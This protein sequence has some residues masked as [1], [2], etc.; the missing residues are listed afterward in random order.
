LIKKGVNIFN[1]MLTKI[2]KNDRLIVIAGIA[3]LSFICWRYMAKMSV[4]TEFLISVH[5]A[6]PWKINDLVSHFIMWLIMMI[7]MMLP[8]AGPMI[9]TFSFISRKRKQKE[10][11]YVNTSIFVMGYL[12]VSA[13]FS[14]LVSF[15]QWW[16]HNNA[17]LTSVGASNSYLFSG[18]LLLAAGIFQWSKIKQA[19]LRFC[20]NPFNFLMANW[21]EGIPG[22][23][24][25]GIKHGLLCTGCCW[26]LML[27]MF[28]GGVMN[29][30]WMI[31][32]TAIIL[33]EKMAPR[34]DIF[35]KAVGVAMAATGIYFI[36]T[37][38]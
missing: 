36:I 10:Q 32:I 7:A 26:A 18:V 29:L 12:I 4:T 25:M 5:T 15:L 33:I 13:G 37:K 2:L 38:F 34:G 35:A 17:L 22:A 30:L 14:F 27:L 3:A 1:A 6:H 8:T 21:K 23:L 20:R 9:S 19:C 16:L 11:P 28:V 31:V 24:H